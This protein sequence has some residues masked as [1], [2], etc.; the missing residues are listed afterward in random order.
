MD[1]ATLVTPG[2]AIAWHR[3]LIAQK[4]D[5]SARRKPGRPVIKKELAALV[6][7]MAEE[8]ND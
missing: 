2:D 3:N 5:G 8:N 6:V 7:R 1:I 4:C